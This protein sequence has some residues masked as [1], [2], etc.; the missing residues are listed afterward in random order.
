MYY[1]VGLD[2]GITSVGWAVIENDEDGNPIRIVDLGSRIFDA[3]EVPKTGAPLAEARRNAR[4]ARRRNRRKVHRINRVKKLLGDYNIISSKALDEL[5]QNNEK[6]DVYTLRVAGLDRL[7]KPEEISRVLIN[8]VKKRGYKSNSKSEEN[9]NSETG[10]ALSAISDNKCLMEQK[11]Y[12]TVAEMYLKDDKFKLKYD[13]GDNICDKHGNPVVKLR[14]STDD[15]KTTV[16]RYLL[17]DEVNKILE[18]QK[19]YNNKITDEF[20]QEY[21]NIFSSQRNYDEGP[22]FPSKYG[23]NLIENMLGNCTFEDGE[24]RAAKATYTFEKFKMLQDFNSIKLQKLNL[25]ESKKGNIYNKTEIS[26]SLTDEEKILLLNK[27]KEKSEL[28]ISDIRKLLQIPYDYTFNLIDYDFRNVAELEIKER[29]DDIEKNAKKKLTEFQSFHKIRIA[30]DKYEKGYISKLTED[31]LDNIATI[32]TLY[33]SDEKRIEMLIEKGFKN[34]IIEK[35]LPLSFSKVGHLSIKAMKK[36]I[37][38]LQ[39]GLTYDKAVNMVYEDFRGKII[40]DKKTKLSLNDIEEIANPVV[41]RGVSQTIKVVNAI[42]NKYG[43]PD[44]INIELAREVSKNFADRKKMEKSMLENMDTNQKVINEIKGKNLKDNITG[45]D[46]VKYKLWKEQDGRC[47]YSGE[48]IS[49]EALFTKEVDVDHII[50]YSKCFDDSYNNKVLVKASENRMKTNRTPIEYLTESNKNVDEYI[51]RI[52]NMYSNNRKKR[53]NLLKE[54][55]TEE[56]EANWKERNLKDTQYITRV[57]LNLMR[58]HLA[59]KENRNIAEN[60]RV[61]AVKGTITSQIRKRLNIEKVREGDKHH[62]MDAAVIAITTESMIQK[63]TNYEKN[64]EIR[65]SDDTL[66]KEKYYEKFP[67]PYEN[68][69]L[70]LK[71]RLMEDDEKV[72][73]A[74]KPLDILEYKINGYPKSIFVSRMPKRK[75]KGSAHKE[76]IASLSKSGNI[77]EKKSLTTLKLNKESEID[78]YYNKQDDTL[79]YNALRNKLIEYDGKADLAFKEPFYKPKSDGT[80]GPLVKKVKIESKSTSNV[81]LKNMKGVAGN[82][83]TVR[84]DVFYVENEGY[85]F[86]P[87][88]VADTIKKYLPNKA[89]VSG[90]KQSDWKEMDDKNFIFSVYPNDLLYIKSKNGIKLTPMNKDSKKEDINVNEIFGY[91]IKCNI[92]NAQIA[93]STHDRIYWQQSLGVKSLLEIK[94][95]EVDVLGNYTE[96][97]LPEK[98]MKFN[99]K[100]K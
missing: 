18:S 68:F 70:E 50:P 38:Y 78:G 17:L 99:F 69:E 87:I 26:R 80:K 86:I 9:S 22:A 14:N 76:T 21:I 45:Q 84:I 82:G 31:D 81:Y 44:L 6:T 98:R 59:F 94:K 95:Y 3:A 20:I 37:P 36:I 19:K 83:D 51:V 23:G 93:I 16:E 75:V 56:D 72:K 97:K 46:I 64:K 24:K 42:V 92:A 65:H 67:M 15:Y 12:R 55:F 96:V 60:K 30:L 43:K 54:H 2:I 66:T 13:S 40:K 57:I 63:I 62:A 5:Y 73:G 71:A 41:R 100:R 34:E 1:R 90:K 49:P 33:K 77:V 27:F 39:E 11:E 61:M 74:L 29:I 25:T 53:Q 7:L 79:L 52:E 91:Y 88:Y 89:C 32:L 4:S 35:L 48:Y 10:K 28:K 85:Y 8:L 47:P 58:N